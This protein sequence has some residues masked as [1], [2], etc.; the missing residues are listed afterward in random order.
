MKQSLGNLVLRAIALAMCAQFALAAEFRSIDGSGNNSFLASQGAANTR[1]IRF[2][3]DA[4][5]PDGIGDA[6]AE[7]GKP[8]PRDISNTVNAQLASVANSRNL[9][10]WV[11]QWGQF[12]THDMS[13]IP[14]SAVANTLSTGLVGDFAISINS[15]GDPLGPGPIA[16][17]RSVFDPT[18]GDG[19]VVQ[20]PRGPVPVP[21]WQLNANTS[22]LD[23]SQ[24]YGSDDAT[25]ASLR[26]FAG[27]KLLTSA[28][29]LL[30]PQ[31]AEGKFI[32]GDIRANEN[33]SLS[34]THALF[35]REHNRLAD[36]LKFHEGSLSDEEI[37]QWARKIV[38]AEVQAI[39]YREFLPALMGVAAPSPADYFYDESTDATITTA[40]SAAAF[41]FGH[42]MQSPDIL[43]VDNRGVQVG[44]IPLA[45]ASEHHPVL[46]GDPAKVDLVLRGLASQVAQENDVYVVDGLRNIF[47]GPPGAGGNDL[48]AVDIQRGRDLGLLSNYNQMRIAYNL[49]PISSFSELTSDPAVQASLASVYGTPDNIDAWV[50]MI[51]EDHL[52]DSSLGPLAQRIIE[53]QFVR[54][55][56][57]DRFFF[58]GDPDLQSDL[59]ASVIDL[60]TITLGRLIE[61][62]TGVMGLPENV[63]FAAVVV[64]EPA[65]V[66]LL[67]SV[68]SA[69]FRR[70]CGREK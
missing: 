20:T 57:G 54:L 5:Y 7:A 3:Y 13:R 65:T 25:A 32:A 60:N 26:T 19:S 58:A 48:A 24:V 14:T 52:P 39:T 8:N 44:A 2:G 4:D 16:F 9:S 11:V 18:T 49:A 28:D 6:I 42:S 33:T 61:L 47:F 66:V 36:L 67:V 22:Y 38:G 45:R 56:D 15:P 40:F 63:F 23:A 34:A 21:R 35:V 10:D 59:V 30:P 37:Y 46:Q 68:I 31:D 41:R 53:S 50:A 64:P 29:G 12:I 70:S 62:N 1:V 27:G 43:L 17:D 51:A 69:L 55:R